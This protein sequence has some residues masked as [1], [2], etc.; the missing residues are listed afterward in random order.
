M[1]FLDRGRSI[2]VIANGEGA[3]ETLEKSLH[4]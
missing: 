2:R 4:T 3:W 1:C